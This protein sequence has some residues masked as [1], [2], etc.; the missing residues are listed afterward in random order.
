MKQRKL[1]LIS[2]REMSQMTKLT[3]NSTSWK[4]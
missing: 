1:D 3:K 4:Y 2:S